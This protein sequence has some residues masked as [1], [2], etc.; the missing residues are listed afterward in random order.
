MHTDQYLAYDSHH[1]Q[2]VKRGIVK[3]LYDRWADRN[4]SLCYFQGEKAS[5]TCNVY[6]LS[7]LQKIS[8]T[9]KQVTSSEPTTEFK[10]TAVLSCPRNSD[11]AYETTVRS[12]LVWPKDPADP[13]KQVYIGKTGKP[14]KDRIKEHDWD[15]RIACTHT[16]GIR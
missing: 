6:P 3:C 13:T 2:S 16:F 4:L 5:V 12:L 11:T 14:M 15:I 9:R 7:F 10:T 1:P 8:K